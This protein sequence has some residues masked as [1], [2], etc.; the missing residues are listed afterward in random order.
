MKC[1]NSNVM[2]FS[3]PIWAAACSL[4]SSF[5]HLIGRR[6][7]KAKSRHHL[8]QYTC[9]NEQAALQSFERSIFGD[10]DGETALA[11]GLAQQLA[12]MR[13]DVFGGLQVD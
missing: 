8:L 4:S 5:S 7:K 3:T 9:Y 13:L 12:R 2:P 11:S 6:L 1:E 10:A